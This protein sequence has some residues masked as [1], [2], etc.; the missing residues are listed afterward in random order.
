MYRMLTCVFMFAAGWL[1]APDS[2]FLLVMLI[3][4]AVPTALNVHTLATL[5]ANREEEVGALLFWQ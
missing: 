1:V 2:M 3:Q 4:N 5:H